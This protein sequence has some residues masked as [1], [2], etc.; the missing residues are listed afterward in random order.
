MKPV[1]KY[2]GRVGCSRYRTVKSAMRLVF[3]G[4]S[5]KG[6]TPDAPGIHAAPA[7]AAL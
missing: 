3:V 4:C 7:P 5:L 2:L 6:Q 1:G